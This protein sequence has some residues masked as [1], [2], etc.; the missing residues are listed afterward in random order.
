MRSPSEVDH[1]SHSSIAMY[2]RCPRSWAYQY[3][4][5]L[6][7][8]PLSMSLIRGTAVDRAATKNL[9]QKIRSGEDLAVDEVCDVAEDV[10]R[11]EVDD[12]GGPSE[13]NWEGMSF[14]RAIDS[15]VAL[16]KIHMLH[17]AP[18]IDP[19]AVQV[20]LH[21][22]LPDGRDFVGYLDF[23]ETDGR[24]GDIKTGKRRMGQ[25][26][27]DTDM[28]AHAY[29]YLRHGAIDFTYWRTIDTGNQRY[30]ETVMTHRT[31]TQ[32]AWYERAASDVSASINAAAFPP[33]T[34]GWWCGATR[35]SFWQRCQ[36]ENRPP[37]FP[38]DPTE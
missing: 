13:I 29:A 31:N 21:R 30:E 3:L 2:L 36:V 4:E 15:A 19:A 35:C 1:L 11:S 17:H 28:Q 34:G 5:Q 18:V 16:T 8:G 7:R 22:P 38:S 27:A 10:I 32:A 37:E 33:N 14:P 23:I 24:V 20:E 9:R 25:P 12:K 6:P 26:S